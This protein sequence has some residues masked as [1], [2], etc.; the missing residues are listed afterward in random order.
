MTPSPSFFIVGAPKAGTTSLNDYLAQYP[1]IFM[2][3]AKEMHY[4]GSDLAQKK[5]KNAALTPEAYLAH[6]ATMTTE[7]IAG[8]ASVLYLKS[9]TAAREIYE[10]CPEAK[11]IVML[12]QPTD[13]IHS[14]HAQLISQGDEDTEDFEAALSLEPDRKA[15]RRLPVGVMV[16]DDGLFYR[17]VAQIGT[18]LA[19]YLKVFPS[20]QVHVIFF[21]DFSSDPQREVHRVREFLGL[22]PVHVLLDTSVRN[23][24]SRPRS[25]LL[26]R[27]LYHPPEWLI[28]VVKHVG[29]REKW[30]NLRDRLRRFNNVK[31][32]RAPLS[33]GL[34]AALTQE[35]T[36]EIEKL[37]TLTGRDLAAWRHR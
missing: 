19:R 34:R 3:A 21:E 7:K 13:L 14:L 2:P 28:H 23:P 35:F 5:R 9:E 15:G 6:F 16:P 33:P 12:R 37:E 18:Q 22:A 26:T 24:N 10:F 32:S 17:E 36:P 31:A 11:I 20:D 8:E 29:T 27:V 25:K 30:I 4:F 1:D